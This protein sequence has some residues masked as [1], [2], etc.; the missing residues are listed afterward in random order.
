MMAARQERMR[1]QMIL[2][3]TA[4]RLFAAT[5]AIL[6]IPIA[7]LAYSTEAAK[8]ARHLVRVTSNRS[9]AGIADATE[10][11]LTQYNLL[12]MEY[13]AQ[14][15]SHAAY[16]KSAR[17]QLQIIVSNFASERYL[18]FG[19]PAPFT[20]QQQAD[21]K[22]QWRDQVEIMNR[23]PEACD[24]AT[25]TAERV[26][27]GIDDKPNGKE[28]VS[29]AESWS[30][31]VEQEY[32]AGTSDAV[33][34]SEAKLD[35]LSVQYRAGQ[36]SL[37]SYCQSGRQMVTNMETQSKNQKSNGIDQGLVHLIIMKRHV[38]HFQA[39]CRTA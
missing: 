6:V 7:A 30:K 32:A 2:L 23:S 38:Y 14:L 3:S 27:F 31:M 4:A 34:V 13:K 35:L 5:L 22:K 19:S 36:L 12:T 25:T 26:V 8:D 15:I 39:L 17:P 16:C 11:G 33:E 18:Q 37:R 21:I 29:N 9:V 24:A 10:V 20:E 1:Q 28:A